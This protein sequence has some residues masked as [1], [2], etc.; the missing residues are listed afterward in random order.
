M[1]LKTAARRSAPRMVGGALAPLATWLVS[2]FIP[3]RSWAL[4]ATGA[5]QQPI[6]PIS[7]NGSTYCAGRVA[8]LSTMIYY[9]LPLHRQGLYRD[10]GYREDSLPVSEQ[11]GREVLSLPMYP[12][13]ADEQIQRVVETI[14]AFLR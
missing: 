6:T 3:P 9:P 10:L 12:E 2:A 1:W 4:T 14:G 13:L 7:R 11:A 5:W 8:K